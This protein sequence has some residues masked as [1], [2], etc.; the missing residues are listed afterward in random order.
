MPYRLGGGEGHIDCIQLVYLALQCM[1]I[2]TPPFNED[3]YGMHRRGYLRDLLTWGNRVAG[4][5]YDGDVLL[6]AGQRPMFGVVWELG[7]LH[8]SEMRNAVGWCPMDQLKTHWIVRYSP[9][10]KN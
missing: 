3:W 8:I 6:L 4:P 7:A 5:V 10:S 1:E 9:T 2:P